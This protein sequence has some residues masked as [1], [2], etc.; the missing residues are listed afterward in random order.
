MIFKV[1]RSR[2]RG[3]RLHKVMSLVKREEYV[4]LS[5]IKKEKKS[6]HQGN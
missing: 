3:K 5:F 1:I 4:S 6:D 2:E